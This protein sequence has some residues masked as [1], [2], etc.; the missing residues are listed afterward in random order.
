M[1]HSFAY[2][3]MVYTV[4]IKHGESV[5]SRFATAPS[6]EEESSFTVIVATLSQAAFRF[7]AGNCSVIPIFFSGEG[8]WRL[9]GF[10]TRPPKNNDGNYC[11]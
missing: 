2:F 5:K 4:D 3:K 7:R 10:Y 11:N 8:K 1:A 6:N 9:V